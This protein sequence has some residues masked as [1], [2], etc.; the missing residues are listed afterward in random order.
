MTVKN[1]NI[2]KQKHRI[3]TNKSIAL[4]LTKKEIVFKHKTNS[5]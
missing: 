4:A 5:S 3:G 2:L 1:K